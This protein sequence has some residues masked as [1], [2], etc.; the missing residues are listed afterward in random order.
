MKRQFKGLPFFANM[1][2]I[3]KREQ[4]TKNKK[5]KTISISK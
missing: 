3:A 2:H 5:R 4:E 1:S